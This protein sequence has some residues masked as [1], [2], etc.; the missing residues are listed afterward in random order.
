[1]IPPQKAALRLIMLNGAFLAVNGILNDSINGD[2]GRSEGMEQMVDI[3]DYY[4]SLVSRLPHVNDISDSKGDVL[5]FPVNAF[6]KVL[7]AI[8]VYDNEFNLLSTS[9]N[10]L[11]NTEYNRIKKLAEE[12]SQHQYTKTEIRSVK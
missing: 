11:V 2:T 7:A 5:M 12:S 6:T 1:M 9:Q 4:E 10:I 3:F 8:N